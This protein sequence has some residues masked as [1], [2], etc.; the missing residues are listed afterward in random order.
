MEDLSFKIMEINEKPDIT[1]I[2]AECLKDEEILTVNIP[3]DLIAN[4]SFIRA[5]LNAKY[6]IECEIKVGE[7]I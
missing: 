6:L 3:T 5:A 7:I 1:V 4:R 2:T